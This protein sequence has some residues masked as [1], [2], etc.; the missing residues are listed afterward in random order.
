MPKIEYPGRFGKDGSLIGIKCIKTIKYR[1]CFLYIPYKLLISVDL[2]YK[3]PEIKEIIEK[4]ELF[5]K[6]TNK[7]HE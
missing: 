1:E 2:A 3:V 4:H 7:E 6:E 5:N